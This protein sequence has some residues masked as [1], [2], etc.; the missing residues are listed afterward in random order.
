[1]SLATNKILLAG[2]QS[3][4]PGAYFQT[5]TISA[6]NTGNG[7]VIPAGLF[8][9]FPSANVSVL[10]YNGSSNATVMAANT[11]GVVFSDGINVYAKDSAGTATVTLLEIN[12]GQAAGETYA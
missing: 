2:A 8:V 7:T 12:G 9:M 4:T 11:G 3:N 6:V 1:M 5:V 10:A